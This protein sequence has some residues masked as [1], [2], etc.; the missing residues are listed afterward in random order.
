M[1]IALVNQSSSLAL[2]GGLS[3]SVFVGV[4][5]PG[6]FFDFFVPIEERARVAG[7]DALPAR[8]RLVLTA[9]V[10]RRVLEAHADKDQDFGFVLSYRDTAERVSRTAWTLD[11]LRVGARARS[12]TFTISLR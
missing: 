3:I 2:R 9:V 11:A 7:F 12:V 8:S 1:T 10:P 4:L 6:I 5:P